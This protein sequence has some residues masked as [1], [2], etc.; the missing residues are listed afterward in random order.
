MYTF[1]Q[2]LLVTDGVYQECIL[3][4]ALVLVVDSVYQEYMLPEALSPAD[5]H[6]QSCPVIHKG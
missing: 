2:L 3:L 1:V 6:V 5:L 4:E